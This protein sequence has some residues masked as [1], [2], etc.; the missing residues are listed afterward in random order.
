ML[1][2]CV[3]SSTGSVANSVT[4]IAISIKLINIGK[5]HDKY[6]IKKYK[7]VTN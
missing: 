3:H 2:M 7:V 1:S 6:T 4:T 5:E